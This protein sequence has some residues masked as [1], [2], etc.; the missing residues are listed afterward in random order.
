MG[1]VARYG[2]AA[3]ASALRCVKEK[4]RGKDYPSLVWVGGV[5]YTWEQ[6]GDIRAQSWEV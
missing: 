3:L 2:G 5:W 1:K 4:Q 6:S